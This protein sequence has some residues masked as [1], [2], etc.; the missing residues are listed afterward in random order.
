MAAYAAQLPTPLRINTDAQSF[1]GM[2][3]SHADGLGFTVAGQKTHFPPGYPTIIEWLEKM[4]LGRSWGLVGFNIV[5]MAIAVAA[6]MWVLRQWLQ[7]DAATSAAAGAMMLLSWGAIKHFTIPVSEPTFAA[8]SGLA[9]ASWVAA[10]RSRKFV[11]LGWIGVGLVLTAAAIS[12]RSIGIALL[13][14]AAWSVVIIALRWREDSLA[15]GQAVGAVVQLMRRNRGRAVV[16]AIVGFVMLAVFAIVVSRTQ[17]VHEGLD[18]AG[19]R[20]GSGKAVAFILYQRF[21]E[22]GSMMSNIPNAGPDIVH[23]VETTF[24]LFVAAT[25]LFSL[26]RRWQTWRAP[27]VYIATYAGILFVW[28]YDADVRFWIPISILIFGLLL[29]TIPDF[30]PAQWSYRAM[31]GG[32]GW[33]AMLGVLWLAYSTRITYSG[34]RFS[35]LFGGELNRSTYRAASHS[36][37]PIEPEKVSRDELKLLARYGKPYFDDAWLN[38]FESPK[39]KPRR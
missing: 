9:L 34:S 31:Y 22:L 16:G 39:A 13:P 6:G 35:E 26:F 32:F 11:A 10:E 4:G 12:V 18:I 14:A 23:R 33:F 17:Y 15:P 30:L 19:R 20:G 25:L 28:P 2:A 38:Q 7:V 3:A 8:A 36:S 37:L 5:A 21:V 29:R 27:D 24:G 1:L